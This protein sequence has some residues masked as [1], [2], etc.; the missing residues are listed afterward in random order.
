MSTC[1][2]LHRHVRTSASTSVNNVVFVLLFIQHCI[3]KIFQH[4]GGGKIDLKGE[5]SQG[6]P[7]LSETL[8]TSTVCTCTYVCVLHTYIHTYIHVHTTHSHMS[9]TCTAYV[10]VYV[11]YIHT[12]MT[13]TCTYIIHRSSNQWCQGCYSSSTFSQIQKKV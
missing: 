9:D 10:H 6:S 7:L 13:C 11:H 1:R 2:Q 5:K 3:M 12:Y 4:F 8:Y